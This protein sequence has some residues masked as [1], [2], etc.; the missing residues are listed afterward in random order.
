MSLRSE[1]KVLL[2]NLDSRIFG[3]NIFEA[4]FAELSEDDDEEPEAVPYDHAKFDGSDCESSDEE[5][6]PILWQKAI[7]ESFRHLGPRSL[8]PKSI[9]FITMLLPILA[10]PDSKTKSECLESFLAKFWSWWEIIQFFE[11][12]HIA[13]KPIQPTNCIW[14]FSLWML[15]KCRFGRQGSTKVWGLWRKRS[16]LY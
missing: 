7:V 3:R 16:K 2:K 4:Y 12:I 13:Y 1:R 15:R 14:H 11:T 8:V 5:M 10:L 9:K 6:C